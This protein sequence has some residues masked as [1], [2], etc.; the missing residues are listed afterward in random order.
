VLKALFVND[1]DEGRNNQYDKVGTLYELPDLLELD[2]SSNLLGDNGSISLPK[3]S[4]D[5]NGLSLLSLATNLEVLNLSANNL[6]GQSLK[7]LFK[8]V[9][10]HNLETLNLS[11]NSINTLPPNEILIEVCPNLRHLNLVSNLFGSISKLLHSLCPDLNLTHL[12]LFDEKESAENIRENPLC[13]NRLDYRSKAICIIPSLLEL[14][15]V[16]ITLSEKNKY[17]MNMIVRSIDEESESEG[18]SLRVWSNDDHHEKVEN[19]KK[20]KQTLNF[21]K[22]TA[23]NLS[24]IEINKNK[25]NINPTKSSQYPNDD[26]ERSRRMKNATRS[27]SL[28]KLSSLENQVRLLSGFAEEQARSTM[29][30]AELHSNKGY[31]GTSNDSKGLKI[32]H[33]NEGTQITCNHESLNNKNVAPKGHVAV[34]TSNV[35]ACTD[36]EQRDFSHYDES[37]NDSSIPTLQERV[38]SR[39]E[40]IYALQHCLRSAYYHWKVRVLTSRL[41]KVEDSSEEYKNI[42][43]ESRDDNKGL[44]QELSEIAYQ[45]ED[46]EK[47]LDELKKRMNLTV[48]K[49]E[50]SIEKIRAS[51]KDEVSFTLK[52]Q[53]EQLIDITDK[54]RLKVKQMKLMEEGFIAEKRRM[55]NM[56]KRER[57]EKEDT[58]KELSILEKQNDLHLKQK[59]DANSEV[60]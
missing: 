24:H 35:V 25:V 16:P 11:Y 59:E 42:L 55:K 21:A 46:K 6:C 43:K 27:L 26:N 47:E 19:R 7:S 34:Q 2:I 30:L 48:Q 29:I 32:M 10:M 57:V 58:R 44:R 33:G 37:I 14:D 45:L 41:L 23:C 50:R 28:Q 31:D 60:V 49:T 22:R 53:Q 15:G 56:L 39:Q 54:L 38:S 17:K 18:M 8:N 13:R 5:Q 4:L 40:A 9:Q 1:L 12:K 3:T 20:S 52:A 36:G 51:H